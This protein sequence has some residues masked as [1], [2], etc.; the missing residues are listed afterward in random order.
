MNVRLSSGRLALICLLPLF[1]LHASS[2]ADP[3]QRLI[4]LDY[5]AC[6]GLRSRAA[7]VAIGAGRAREGLQPEWQRQFNLCRE[8]LGVQYLR[9]HGIFHDDMGVYREDSSGKPVYNWQK[10]DA[11]YDYLIHQGVHPFVELSFMPAALALNTHQRIFRWGAIISPPR[12]FERWG[13]LVTEFTKHVT[14]RYGPEEVRKWYFEV[15]NEAN[16]PNFWSGTQAEYFKLYRQSV[17]A[18]KSVDPHYRVGGPVTAGCAWLSEM[19][20]FC[21]QQRVP[22]D[23]ISTHAYGSPWKEGVLPD[24]GAIGKQVQ[25]CRRRIDTSSRAGLELH[26]SEWN[27]SWTLHDPLRDT[28][29]HAPYILEQAKLAAK[30]VTTMPYWVFSDIFEEDGVPTR[31]FHGGFG[32]LTIDG[33][34][35]PSYW[36][37][38]F[39]NFL[40]D[41]EL[42]NKD[43]HSWA[44]RD[45]AGGVQVLCWDISIPKPKFN[46][47]KTNQT[48]T[49]A[50]ATTKEPANIRV[51]NLKPGTYSLEIYRIGSQMN[52]PYS[53]YVEMGAP[54]RPPAAELE[55]LKQGSRGGPAST[56]TVKVNQASVFLADVEMRENAVALVVLKPVK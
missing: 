28:Y 16:L 14:N 3:G 48:V 12:S 9:C 32:L 29:V 38:R 40:G 56:E 22:L 25:G 8:E 17:E 43:A 36:A 52:D 39:L 23:F 53:A 41:E 5:N 31:E 27:S 26:F 35:K 34:R 4:E 37:L 10:V 54:E 50:P 46:G 47:G 15:W 1:T 33:I 18:I 6:H 7:T 51:K 13:E 30:S 24:L 21:D 11:F 20:N 2:A 55:M 19:I 42:D 44:C 45:K 49:L